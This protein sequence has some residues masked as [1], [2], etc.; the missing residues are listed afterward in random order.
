MNDLHRCKKLGI[1]SEQFPIRNL[2]FASFLQVTICHTYINKNVTGRRFSAVN[3][4]S[5]SVC[6]MHNI[7]NIY[8]SADT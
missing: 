5:F 8:T 2:L 7:H 6:L 3:V 4:L 1:F